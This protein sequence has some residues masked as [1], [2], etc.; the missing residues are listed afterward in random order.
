MTGI[1]PS[2]VVPSVE[3]A[4]Q[5]QRL[6]SERSGRGWSV[7]AQ[8][9]GQLG[10]HRGGQVGSDGRAMGVSVGGAKASGNVSNVRAGPDGCAK[11]AGG[12]GSSSSLQSNLARKPVD[13][14]TERSWASS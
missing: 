13:G 1:L 6:R 2:A 5:A 8:A 11:G 10:R 12:G 4:R 14:K 7:R 3:A 9:A